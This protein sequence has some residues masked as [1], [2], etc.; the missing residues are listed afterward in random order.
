MTGQPPPDPRSSRRNLSMDELIAI[1]VALIAIGSILFWGLS[2]DGSGFRLGQLMSLFQD[3]EEVQ[4]PSVGETAVADEDLPEPGLLPAPTA[5]AVLTEEEE[6][7]LPGTAVTEDDRRVVT[8]VPT[9]GPAL[10]LSPVMVA[11]PPSP[12]AIEFPDVS[13]AYWAYPFITNLTQRGILTGM[14]DGTFQPDEPVTRAQYAAMLDQVLPETP[15]QSPIAFSDVSTDYWASSAIDAAVQRGFL[16]GYPEGDFQPDQPITRVQVL[17]SLVNGMGISTAAN[18]EAI[19]QR[20]ADTNQIPNWAI[21]VTATATASGFVV[22]HPDP[23]QL[24]PN[25]PASRAE[26]AAMMYQALA[27]TNQVE[28]IASEYVVQP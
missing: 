17:T 22:N 19:V 7:L 13:S 28:P 1:F 12:T 16:K 14:D 2:R 15:T 26:V 9:Q 24:N 10:P 8:S 5:T 6:S 20:F 27:A 4:I 18:P 25:Q 23:N 11:P 21:P 3:S